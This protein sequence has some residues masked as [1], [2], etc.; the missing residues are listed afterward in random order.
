MNYTIS[1][2]KN[3]VNNIDLSKKGQKDRLSLYIRIIESMEK[4]GIA[5]L[6]SRKDVA[7]IG[8]LIES[9]IKAVKHILKKMDT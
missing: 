5:T 6:E 8:Q 3:Y 1:E 7:N 9:L 4:H 2:L